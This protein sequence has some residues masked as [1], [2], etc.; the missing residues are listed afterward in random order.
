MALGLKALAVALLALM[1]SA[2]SGTS[3]LL[4]EPPVAISSVE[5]VAGRSSIA[6]ERVAAPYR[7]AAETWLLN[8]DITL[9][10]KQPATLRIERVVI[11]YPGSSISTITLSYPSDRTA[12]ELD[13]L[14]TQTFRVPEK[15]F[16]PFPVAPSVSVAFH[17][18]GYRDPIVVTRDLVE[19]ESKVAGRAYRFPIDREDLPY[20]TYVSDDNTHVVGS[21]HR[22]SD[23]QR[24]AYDYGVFRW[25]GSGWSDVKEGSKPG[26]RRKTQDFLIW[27]VPIRAMAD[28]WV[29]RCHSSVRDQR[30][31]VTGEAGGNH[32]WI[33]HAKGEVALYAHLRQGSVPRRLCPR[34]GVDFQP[35]QIK[36]KVGQQLGVA[37]NSGHSTGPHLH[38]HVGTTGQDAT[39]QGRPLVFRDVRVRFAGHG[40]NASEPCTAANKSFAA[41]ARAATGPWQLVDPVFRPGHPELASHGLPDVCF[42][43]HFDALT[44]AGYGM[45]WLSG[46]DAGG[47][48]Y[49]NVVFTKTPAQVVRFGLTGVQYQSELDEAI[50]AGFR[51]IHVESYLRSGQVRYAF[52]AEKSAGPEFRAYHRVAVSS[53][54]DGAKQLS[55]RGFAP[56]AVSVAP[57]PGGGKVT[58]LWE[59]RN[60]GSWIANAAIPVSQYQKWLETQAKAGRKLVYLDGWMSGGKAM[61][62]AIVA[63]KASPTYQARHDL[64][65]SKYQQEYET[66]TGK[67]LRTRSVTAYRVGNNVRYAALWR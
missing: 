60:I 41:V 12:L 63:S 4:A 18:R 49:L 54:N 1:A 11:R 10:N 57:G 53:H 58:A 21:G 35:N 55:M 16:F 14:S 30:P 26:R 52:I 29:L 33:V 42:Q 47:K 65:P 38:V 50:D 6:V 20:G 28:G 39:E 67:G 22:D 64:S 2:G 51:P 44:Q 59:K 46:F 25:T 3:A 45:S 27:G 48:T 8:L 37:G 40:W 66:W 23:G 31:G 36:V 9:G 56:V 24:F 43:D 32:Y 13:G 5:P 61:L 17:F 34:E 62:S 19:W 7:G 15:R